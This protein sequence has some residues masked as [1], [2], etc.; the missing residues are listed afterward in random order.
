MCWMASWK[1]TRS[2]DCGSTTRIRT[3]SRKTSL[4]CV[5]LLLNCHTAVFG[6]EMFNHA[7]LSNPEIPLRTRIFLR[8]RDRLLFL[9]QIPGREHPA[10]PGGDG[11]FFR[12][13]RVARNVFFWRCPL[14]ILVKDP[15]LLAALTKHEAALGGPDI[16]FSD[17]LLA[18]ASWKSNVMVP[19][20]IREVSR[21]SGECPAP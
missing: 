13:C 10:R 1:T 11:G 8:L 5:Y 2:C 19:A 18:M 15:K 4:D 3:A 17:H 7:I 9:L 6:P 16:L 20:T 21:R 12:R 14:V